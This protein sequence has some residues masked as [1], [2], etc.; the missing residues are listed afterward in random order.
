MHDQLPGLKKK[1][2]Y[3]GAGSGLE[4]YEVPGR[5]D[6]VVKIPRAGLE[7]IMRKAL[8]AAVKLI[9]SI[10]DYELYFAQ[11][12]YHKCVETNLY[13]KN[14]LKLRILV[15]PY[16]DWVLTQ[17]RV[18]PIGKYPDLSG[19]EWEKDF[20]SIHYH[21]WSY[22]VGLSSTNEL[23]GFFN[24]GRDKAGR[25]LSF[26]IG[27][28]TSSKDELIKRLSGE[29]FDSQLTRVCRGLSTNN[30]VKTV[31]MY[32]DFV[33]SYINPNKVEEYWMSSS[34]KDGVTSLSMQ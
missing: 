33:R 6:Y 29:Y 12:H 9:N 26:D 25:V 11:V 27:S 22:G 10:Q 4:A 5:S 24:R 2:V 20:L 8:K 17:D 34:H 28:I 19:F 31:N 3:L 14:I 16:N 1:L 18:S 13:K 30:K 15:R 32:E 7:G 23:F 21:F